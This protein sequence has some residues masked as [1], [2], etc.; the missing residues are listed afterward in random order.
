M[1][2]FV[3]GSGSFEGAFVEVVVV[4]LVVVVVVS[5]AVEVVVSGSVTGSSADEVWGLVAGSESEVSVTS[6]VS[7]GD[8]VVLTRLPSAREGSDDSSV[9]SA[10]THASVSAKLA[11]DPETMLT[12]TRQIRLRQRIDRF[13]AYAEIESMILFAHAFA[14]SI[15][16]GLA[17]AKRP[18]LT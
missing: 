4:V 6:E 9:P 7:V 18:P 2:G 1:G 17:D 16:A 14:F 3:T 5:V 13:I 8:R 11:K 10:I 15:S 12:R